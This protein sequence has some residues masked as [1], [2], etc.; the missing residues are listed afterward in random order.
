[1]GGGTGGEALLEDPV[2]EARVA[3]DFCSDT[4]CADDLEFGVCLFGDCEVYAGEEIGEVGLVGGG[5]PESVDVYLVSESEKERSGAGLAGRTSERWMP[6]A[7]TSRMRR[8]V[9][10][11]DWTLRLMGGRRSMPLEIA[12]GLVRS[13]DAGGRAGLARY[14]MTRTDHARLSGSELRVWRRLERDSGVRVLESAAESA[15]DAGRGARGTCKTEL[16]E[17]VRVCGGAVRDAVDERAE[18]GPATRLVDAEDVRTWGGGTRRVVRVRHASS[19]DP[20]RG[21]RGIC[22]MRN[23][24]RH[25]TTPQVDLGLERLRRAL[26]P[27]ALLTGS[28]AATSSLSVSAS[29]PVAQRLLA[30]ACA[31]LSLTN[32]N[33]STPAKACQ[34]RRARLFS[35]SP[36][37]L[38]S[39]PVLP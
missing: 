3:R 15:K 28:A 26:L 11:W 9:A 34:E 5:G 36:V 30:S 29:E 14:L 18:D 27:V 8:T 10:S 35:V 4:C 22:H 25:R 12:C 2:V 13:V 33:G 24:R 6:V 16:V 32:G 1:M 20:G 37:R 17:L 7:R 21:G 38:V 31:L 39:L 19:W 23:N